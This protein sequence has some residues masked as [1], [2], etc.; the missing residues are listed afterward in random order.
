M[1]ELKHDAVKKTARNK[2]ALNMPY[3]KLIIYF[4][5]YGSVNFFSRD[6]RIGTKMMA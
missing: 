3:M 1:N 5:K 2:Q 6:T 4:D